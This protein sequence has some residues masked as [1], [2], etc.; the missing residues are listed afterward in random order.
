M[1]LWRESL[2]DT[3]VEVFIPRFT[4]E[5][6]YN[7]KGNLTEMG[8]PL[9]FDVQGQE[10]DAGFSGISEEKLYVE[11]VFHKAFVQVDEEG[12]VAAAATG[13]ILEM[14]SAPSYPPVFK[15]DHPFV[16]L[17]QERTTGYTLFMGKVANPVQ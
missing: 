12:T 1:N 13:I 3:E 15:A 10:Q 16:F 2:K 7:L 4:F 14:T 17:I 8:M 5:R 9:A 11:E 6:D